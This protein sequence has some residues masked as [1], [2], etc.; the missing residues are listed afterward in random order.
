MK[1]LNRKGFTLVELLAVIIILAIVVGITIPA[2]LTT[3]NNAKKKAFQSAADAA[4]DWIDRQYQVATTGIGVGADAAA[5]LD[6]NF[7]SLCGDTGSTC[8]STNTPP[9]YVKTLVTGTAGEGEV[10]NPAFIAAAGIKKD[11]VS[12][13]R[14]YINPSTGRTCVE[15]TPVAGGDYSISRSDTATKTGGAC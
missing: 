13:M 3:T 9:T 4:A 5:T 10:S 15:L 8:T 6:S 14:F 7:S 1:K 12:K 11:A 2:V